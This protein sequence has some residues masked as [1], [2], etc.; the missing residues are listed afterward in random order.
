LISSGQVAAIMKRIMFFRAVEVCGGTQLT[1][2]E[3]FGFSPMSAF[4]RA[5][6]SGVSY[7]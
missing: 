6:V 3:C 7:W 2:S 4:A 1:H 5:L